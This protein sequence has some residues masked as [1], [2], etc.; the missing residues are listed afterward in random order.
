MFAPPD[1][2]VRNPSY[3]ALQQLFATWAA[4][5]GKQVE[6]RCS[7]SGMKTKSRLQCFGQEV[8]SG[9]FQDAFLSGFPFRDLMSSAR[10]ASVVS[11]YCPIPKSDP[12]AV[13]IFAKS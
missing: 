10:W 7:R 11:A 6:Q 9:L 3:I 12:R 5:I 1:T 13:K 2:D 4:R 8:L